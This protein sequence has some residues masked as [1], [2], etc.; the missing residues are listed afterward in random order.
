MPTLTLKN[1]PDD[2]YIHLKEIAK[3]HRRSLNSEILYCLERSLGAHKIDLAEQLAT[4]RS[5]RTLTANNPI[6]E[7]ELNLAKNEGRP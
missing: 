4:A 7:D 6:D 5:L 2:L 1:I 3:I